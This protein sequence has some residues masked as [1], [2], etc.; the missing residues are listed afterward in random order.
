MGHVNKVL[1]SWVSLV[2]DM[3]EASDCRSDRQRCKA[4]LGIWTVSSGFTARPKRDGHRKEVVQKLFPSEMNS[5]EK[6]RAYRAI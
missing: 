3:R 1:S 5:V 4:R 6:S 2:V